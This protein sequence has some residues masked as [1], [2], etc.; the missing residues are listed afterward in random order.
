LLRV[1]RVHRQSAHQQ[2]EG[3]MAGAHPSK[4]RSTGRLHE[5]SDSRTA[6]QPARSSRPDPRRTYAV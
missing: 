2:R 3:E 5:V 4:W 6:L 1:S